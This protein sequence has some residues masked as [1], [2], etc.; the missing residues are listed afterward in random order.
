MGR[1]RPLASPLNPRAAQALF[2]LHPRG[3]WAPPA[4]ARP[5]LALASLCLCPDPRDGSCPAGR[6]LLQLFCSRSKRIGPTTSRENTKGLHWRQAGRGRVGSPAQHDPPLPP[7]GL[8]VLSLN[9]KWLPTPS[10]LDCSNLSAAPISSAHSPHYLAPYRG[11]AFQ[12]PVLFPPSP[13]H[14]SDIK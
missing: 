9:Q 13:R 2:P 1:P 12:Y 14:E 11:V 4:R 10:C 8:N 5:W 3:P 6:V 7:K